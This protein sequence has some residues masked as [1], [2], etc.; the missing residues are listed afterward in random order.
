MKTRTDRLSWLWL[1]VGSLFL[2][3]AAYQSVIPLAAWLAPVF[4]LRF[5]RAR[6]R[7]HPPLAR[8]RR[9]EISGRS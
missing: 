8:E 5:V 1:L 6:S 4:L 9:L 2:P 3:F 7:R